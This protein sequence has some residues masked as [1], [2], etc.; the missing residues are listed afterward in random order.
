M[1]DQLSNLSD[2]GIYALATLGMTSGLLSSAHCVGMCG[3]LV[4]AATKKKPE[5]GLYHIGRLIGYTLIGVGLPYIGLSISGIKENPSLPLISSL[6]IGITF[7][8]LGLSTK[9]KKM[10][11]Y[12]LFMSKL[13]RLNSIVFKQI[14][15]H[16]YQANNTRSFLLGASSALLPCGILWVVLLL[17]LTT[18]NPL[19][20]LTF[21][22]SFWLGTV[23]ALTFAPIILKKIVSP[24]QTRAPYVL[25]SAFILIGIA[26]ISYRLMMFYGQTQGGMSCH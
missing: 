1:L 20:S 11:L 4:T 17:S 16:F 12:K 7:I 3:G 9:I 14:F 19:L 15:S 6:F 18:A 8:T 22:V 2:M 13:N 23:P 5:V 25:S 26:T 10:N 24:L 21:I